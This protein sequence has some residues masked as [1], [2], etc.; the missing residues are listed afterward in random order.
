M[1]GPSGQ[2]D[3]CSGEQHPQSRC[4]GP[5]PQDRFEHAPIKRDAALQPLSR[6]HFNGL[7]RAR[8]LVAAADAAQCRCALDKFVRCWNAEIA[9]HFD[10]EERLLLPLI[11]D[12]ARRRRLLAEHEELKRMAAA[13]QLVGPDP[14]PGWVKRLG[15]LLHDH[16]RWEERELFPSVE[17]ALS[18]P[19]RAKLAEATRKIEEKREGAR[20]R[21]CD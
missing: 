10:D 18:E 7:C 21:Q 4:G 2:N 14:D 17:Q 8:D 3:G 1:E 13:A 16:I 6:E 20:R 12:C 9:G 11:R 5:G 19:D 15:Q